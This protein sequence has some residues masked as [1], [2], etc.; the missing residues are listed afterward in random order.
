MS[1]IRTAPKEYTCQWCESKIKEGSQYVRR[2]E[3]NGIYYVQTKYHIECEHM[4]VSE[5]IATKK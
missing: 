3:F 2:H 5:K 1:K 4:M